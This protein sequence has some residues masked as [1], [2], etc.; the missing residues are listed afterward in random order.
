METMSQ[1]LHLGTRR[2]ILRVKLD[3]AKARFR[4]ATL[5]G[6]NG[7]L[8]QITPALLS[9]VEQNEAIRTAPGFNLDIPYLLIDA[10]GFPVEVDDV[11]RFLLEMRRKYQSALNRFNLDVKDARATY[12]PDLL[13]ACVE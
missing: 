1:L 7:G 2:A 9:E 13:D 5:F 12:L 10:E 4:E 6:H 8:F 11:T 3:E